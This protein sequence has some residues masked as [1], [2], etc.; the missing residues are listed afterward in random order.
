M[1]S[2]QIDVISLLFN[3]I[4]N[5]KWI[6]CKPLVY[7]QLKLKNIFYS[8]FP[9]TCTQKETEKCAKKA[10]TTKTKKTRFLEQQFCAS[11]ENFTQPLVVIVK[12]FR[13]SVWTLHS[14]FPQN[15]G[16]KRLT[17]ERPSTGHV[18]WGPIKSFGGKVWLTDWLN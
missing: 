16:G 8:L 3:K 10:F 6:P 9:W 15:G 14:N 12:T 1:K 4:H 18:I 17:N 11:Q 2:K 7:T 13:R 5:L